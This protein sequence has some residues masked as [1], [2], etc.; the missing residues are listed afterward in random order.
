[1]RKLLAAFCFFV[2]CIPALAQ[3]APVET[4]M[5]NGSSLVGVWHGGLI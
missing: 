5:V 1:M 2:A 3:D 4:V